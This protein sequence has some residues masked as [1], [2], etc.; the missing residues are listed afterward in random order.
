MARG[1]HLGGVGRFQA[2]SRGIVQRGVDDSSLGLRRGGC[3]HGFRT[4][5]TACPARRA[6]RPP[7]RLAA[8]ADARRGSQPGP[9][10]Q[11]A[12]QGQPA[13]GAGDGMDADAVQAGERAYRR[14]HGPGRQPAARSPGA[15]PRPPVPPASTR[16]RRARAGTR[17]IRP[18]RTTCTVAIFPTI[19]APRFGL[20]RVFSN[21]AGVPRMGRMPLVTCL[22]VP[23]CRPGG[24]PWR[25][26]SCAIAN[27]L[28]PA[29]SCTAG[30]ARATASLGRHRAQAAEGGAPARC[31]RWPPPRPPRPRPRSGR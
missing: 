12:V 26:P 30:I 24:Q 2:R 21:L 31:C 11:P 8:D 22:A 6:G 5:A 7:A 10:R 9:G 28:A 19:Q 13:I 16:R 18:P 20:G 25:E 3:R 14:Q 29:S 15:R 1:A 23:V 27:R 4:G 17:S